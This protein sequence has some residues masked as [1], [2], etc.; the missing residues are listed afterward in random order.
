MEDEEGEAM[1][2]TGAN[3]GP[4]FGGRWDFLRER[5]RMVM[6][7]RGGRGRGSE[8]FGFMDGPWGDPR[9]GF[10]FDRLRG[11]I[12]R[13]RSLKRR[14]H[15]DVRA[16]ILILL[17]E[18]PMHGY[19]IMQE[20]GARSGGLWRPS[21]G[22]V[23]PA[24]Q[25][26]EDEGLAR[27]EQEAQGRKVAHL[28][29]EGRAYV[30]EHRDELGTPWETATEDF[31]EELLELRGLVGQV[32]TAT[33]QV[34]QAGSNSQIAE[35]RRLLADTRSQLYQILAEDDPAGTE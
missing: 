31:G 9:G 17:T 21:S 23:Y 24:L 8:S 28:T 10:P 26:L 32:A 20:I 33:M 34:A 1:G 6:A 15:G 11:P 5:L 13:L 30:Q 29:D 3:G 18:Q 35:A 22:A 2:P 12:G 25:Q 14:G 7:S 19:Q 27:I 4:L 16:A